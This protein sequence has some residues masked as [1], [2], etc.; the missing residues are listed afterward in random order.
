MYDTQRPF[1]SPPI[2][3]FLL[4]FGLIA[5]YTLL[6]G[7]SFSVIE[8]SESSVSFTNWFPFRGVNLNWKHNKVEI[9]D[10][11]SCPGYRVT[12]VEEDTS[13]GLIARL[14][15][16]GQACNAYGEDINELRLEVFYETS[17][18]R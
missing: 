8:A 15:L 12:D 10:L 16:A 14:E 3:F 7:I 5:S 18:F 17:R 6:L 11:D 2:A 1:C 4:T 9:P 13:G